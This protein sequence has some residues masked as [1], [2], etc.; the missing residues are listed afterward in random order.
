MYTVSIHSIN[1]IRSGKILCWSLEYQKQVVTL[2]VIMNRYVMIYKPENSTEIL[3]FAVYDVQLYNKR[4]TEKHKS[5][6]HLLY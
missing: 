5:P 3:F 4:S 1:A 2:R 6:G